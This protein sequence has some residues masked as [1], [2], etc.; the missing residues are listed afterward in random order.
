MLIHI[1]LSRNIKKHMHLKSLQCPARIIGWKKTGRKYTLQ[2]SDGQLDDPKKNRIKPSDESKRR[3]KCLRCGQYGHREKTC[4]NPASQD[5]DPNETSTSKRLLKIPFPLFY[6][7]KKII[8]LV[9][10]I[11]F[12][13]YFRIRGK[14]SRSHDSSMVQG[15]T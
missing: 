2:S 8:D 6:F 15:S 9:E 10:K 1:L 13:I 5:L 7:I 11:M 14:N 12:F 4:K 3:H